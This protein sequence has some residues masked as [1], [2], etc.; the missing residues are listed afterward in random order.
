MPP[1]ACGSKNVAVSEQM[2]MSHSLTKYWPPPAHMPWI[3]Q[4]T[5]FHT[6]FARGPRYT[7]GSSWVQMLSSPHHLPDL[8]SMPVQN[9]R[10]PFAWM[11]ATWMSSVVRTI[12]HTSTISSVIVRVNELSWSG[13]LSVIV[14]T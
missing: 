8:M 14:A 5:G 2:T 11:I 6:L 7:P 1:F 9:A 10:S 3:A 4:T 12:L 13:R